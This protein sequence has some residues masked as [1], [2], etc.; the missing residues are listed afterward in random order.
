MI[1]EDL[2]GFEARRLE[3]AP[4]VRVPRVNLITDAELAHFA[5]Q[6]AHVVWGADSICVNLSAVNKAGSLAA[7]LGAKTA[8]VPCLIATDS[9]KLD[10]A[11]TVET[12]MLEEM[13]AE[14][15][16]PERP[17]LCCNIYFEAVP[18]RLITTYFT[19][20]EVLNADQRA[21]KLVR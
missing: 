5:E 16:W 7:A 6:V 4:H 18:A 20:K 21:A 2:P 8:G 9:C 12:I 14:E 10:P 1:G 19:E 15:V 17:E 3:A 11:H 13:A